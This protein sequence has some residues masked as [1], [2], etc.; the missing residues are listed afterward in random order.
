MTSPDGKIVG[1]ETLPL[2]TTPPQPA[3]GTTTADAVDAESGCFQFTLTVL[4]IENVVH[5][6]NL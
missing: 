4:S 5:D 1:D 3:P 2:A 6:G